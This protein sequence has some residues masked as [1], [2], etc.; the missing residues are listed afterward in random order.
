MA[1]DAFPRRAIFSVTIAH[2]LTTRLHHVLEPCQCA[3]RQ[4]R[5]RD[6][7]L[8][9]AAPVAAVRLC[10]ECAGAHAVCAWGVADTRAFHDRYRQRRG[11]ANRLRPTAM[12]LDLERFA[13]AAAFTQAVSKRSHGN[14][15][16]AEKKAIRQGITVMPIAPS[17]YAA[18]IAGI[19]ASKR[20]RSGGPVLAAW[21]KPQAGLGDTGHPPALPHCP[22]HWALS[23]GA[24]IVEA[25]APRLIAHLTLVRVGD[26]CRTLEVMTH[27]D[28]LKTGAMKLLF[29]QQI[30]WLLG[31]EA[32][33]VQGVRHLM[34]GALEHGGD[35]LHEWKRLM[36]FAPAK[37]SFAEPELRLAA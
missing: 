8:G 28:Y 21:F 18:S 32:A 3:L 2:F 11:P 33:E 31:R 23:W 10:L 36:G 7:D 13:T 14:I 22:E 1:S 12:L 20:M 34:Y 9:A 30:R 16:R 29:L 6:F 4:G 25:G 27:G 17:S 26:L 5:L 24:F 19:A 37:L 35:G 15:P